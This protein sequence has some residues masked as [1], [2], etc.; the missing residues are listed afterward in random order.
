MLI[1]GP[2]L[3]ETHP[4]IAARIGILRRM[5]GGGT[6]VSYQRYATIYNQVVGKVAS[7]VPPSALRET[8]ATA[9][10]SV[11]QASSAGGMFRRE[12][13]DAV[14]KA[15]GYEVH[16]CVCGAKIKI[17]ANYPNRHKLR[18]LACGRA[19]FET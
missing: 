2:A 12:A 9:Q 6:D 4:P 8:P 13:L 14:K 7:F 17:P 3:F 16:V 18:C 10:A 1:V 19:R 11:T 5:A 15:A